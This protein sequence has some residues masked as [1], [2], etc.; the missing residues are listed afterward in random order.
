[1]FLASCQLKDVDGP[2]ALIFDPEYA[3]EL[4]QLSELGWLERVVGEDQD[5]SMCSLATGSRPVPERQTAC[6]R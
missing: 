1:V 4:E 3:D 5:M 6:S 2:E